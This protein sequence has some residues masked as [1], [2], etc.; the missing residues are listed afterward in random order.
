MAN[1]DNTNRNTRER[2]AH[3]ARKCSY[4]EFMSCQPINFKGLEGAVGLIRWFERTELVFSRSNCTEDCKVKFA[5]GTLT[6]EALSWWNSFAQPI[7]IE[8]AYKITW[9]EFK[10]LLI[11]K[12]CPRTEVQKMEDEFYHLTVKGNDLKTYVRRFQELATLC[13]T[14]VP[15]SEKMMEVFIRGLPQS[16]EGNVTASK[17]QTLEETINIAQRLIDQLTKHTPVQVSSDH[18]QKFNDRRTF[19]NNNYR[20]DNNNNC[21]N[22][23]TNN[24]YNNH[25]NDKNKR[26]ETFRNTG[27][28]LLNQHLARVLFDSGA[29]KSFV[30]ISLAS[31]LNIPP[32]T[33]D[34]F[35]NIEMADENLVSTNTVI[36]DATLTL[37]NQPFKIDLMLIKLGS[38]DIVIGMDWLSKY[39]AR[40]IYDEKVIHILINGETL[41]IRGAALVARAPYRLAPSE[42]KELSNQL[43][44]LANRG[45]GGMSCAGCGHCQSTS[46]GLGSGSRLY[47]VGDGSHAGLIRETLELYSRCLSLVLKDRSL[48]TNGEVVTCGKDHRWGMLERDANIG[49]YWSRDSSGTVLC[50]GMG[51]WERGGG[52]W[53][54]A[55]GSQ[56]G[57]MGG[58]GSWA[59]WDVGLARGLGIL[60]R[61]GGPGVAT[62]F[63]PNMLGKRI[64][65]VAYKL[66]LPKELSNIHNTFYVSNLKKCLSDESLVIPMKELRLDDK[67]NFMEE[68]EIMDRESQ[69]LKNLVASSL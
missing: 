56:R 34:T 31:K 21:R 37:L 22:T 17:P 6:E 26:Q 55:V 41:T 8:E 46:L 2:E 12:Y 44:E 30:S 62:L 20:N 60:A 9:V 10:K 19:N 28:F 59:Y 35:Y 38:F 33:I 27:M 61:G 39:H 65:P 67:L 29:D 50:G 23:N 18:K 51:S 69:E 7:G 15:N 1:A 5:T 66:E 14:M 68:V 24:R 3:V 52:S 13:P 11:K 40:I 57:D 43:Q 49:W 64:P 25:R 32:I 42:M 48:P 16:I 63:N 45:I 54:G 36:R 4:K 53:E 58:K 47:G